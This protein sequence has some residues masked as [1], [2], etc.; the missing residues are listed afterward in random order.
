[1]ARRTREP[2]RNAIWT[3]LRQRWIEAASGRTSAALT[4]RLSERLGRAYSQQA[5]SQWATGS[6][7]R[8]P[9]WAAICALMDELG[10]DL[11]LHADGTAHLV[12]V[13]HG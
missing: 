11:V 8:R 5:V 9:P 3:A 1:M 12:E 13:I 2:P 7:G 6:D 10:L 4:E